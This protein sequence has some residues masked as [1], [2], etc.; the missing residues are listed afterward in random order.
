[1]LEHLPFAMSNKRTR[2]KE[3][4]LSAIDLGERQA[5]DLLNQDRSGGEEV[6]SDSSGDSSGEET[7][8]FF[9]S[10]S[11]TQSNNNSTSNSSSRSEHLRNTSNG[12]SSNFVSSQPFSPSSQ[13]LR[14]NKTIVPS[15]KGISSS[16]TFQVPPVTGSSSNLTNE[17]KTNQP[18]PSSTSNTLPARK[19]TRERRM[20]LLQQRRAKREL[21]SIRQ[22]DR[23]VKEQARK[24]ESNTDRSAL[25]STG[26]GVDHGYTGVAFSAPPMDRKEDKK[27]ERFGTSRRSIKNNQFSGSSKSSSHNRNTSGG[28][29]RINKSQKR[30]LSE[31]ESLET[32]IAEEMQ[33]TYDALRRMR[34]GPTLPKDSNADNNGGV[35]YKETKNVLVVS[36]RLPFKLEKEG[37]SW[38]ASAWQNEHFDSQLMDQCRYPCTWIGWPGV[39]VD[40]GEQEHVR[41]HLLI[42]RD[43]VSTNIDLQKRV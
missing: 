9:S 1:M 8:D 12:S 33:K 2:Q 36:F 23:Q 16:F 34:E 17:T 41:D 39:A 38:V 6:H 43:Y 11:Q 35:G 22:I 40:V 19:L 37:N 31:L 4:I 20:E 25:Q 3:K 7:D 21:R 32:K 18:F 28:S 27:K 10:S 13:K 5:D 24:T 15:N 29:T 26:W 30:T 42:N 14:D